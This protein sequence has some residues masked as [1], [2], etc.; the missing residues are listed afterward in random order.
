MKTALVHRRDIIGVAVVTK[1]AALGNRADYTINLTRKGI[2][3]SM[4][5]RPLRVSFQVLHNE[6]ART[7]SQVFSETSFRAP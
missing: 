5:P 3:T 2:E 7:S 1:N 6:P 4:I